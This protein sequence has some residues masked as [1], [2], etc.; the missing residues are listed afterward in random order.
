V[1]G[2]SIFKNFYNQIIG[3]GD[4]A[5]CLVGYFILSH[6]VYIAFIILQATCTFLIKL[7]NVYNLD[8]GGIKQALTSFSAH[9]PNFV[10]DGIASSLFFSKLSILKDV[11]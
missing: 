9:R 11:Q 8:L 5:Y 4:I 1:S 2:L 3:C 10:F 7:F 6:P